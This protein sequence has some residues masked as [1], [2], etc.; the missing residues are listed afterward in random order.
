MQLPKMR[1]C[2]GCAAAGF[3]GEEGAL[4][5]PVTFFLGPPSRH[6]HRSLGGLDTHLSFHVSH[7]PT[8]RGPS[9]LELQRSLPC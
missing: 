5:T 6:L 7:S 8:L 4:V 1:C 3:N 9:S 2:G